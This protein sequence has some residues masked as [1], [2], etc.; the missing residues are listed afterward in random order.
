[1]IMQQ[2]LLPFGSDTANSVPIAAAA[3]LAK[4]H[5]ANITAMFYP[6]LPDPVIVD[7]MSG[8][9]VSYDGLDDEIEAQKASAGKK[10]LER[11]A[12]CIPP[13]INE[14]LNLDMES[15]SN[16]RQ[17][18]EVCRIHDVSLV[19]RSIENPHWQTLFEMALFEGGRPVV[20]VP[21][22]WNKPFGDTVGIAWNHSTETA[23]VLALS[24]PIIKRAK[25]VYIIEV[26]GWVHAGPDGAGL[27]RYLAGHGIDS[28]FKRGPSAGNAGERVLEVAE[29]A[30]VD[31]LIK[32]AFTQSRLTQMIFGGATRAILDQAKIP[33]IFAH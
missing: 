8:G 27:Q 3:D 13:V 22:N 9:V 26:D 10:I 25:K 29:K 12:I 18:G 7:P 2:I 17:V 24:M 20:V 15:L 11:A 31:F 6:R 19:G 14:K 5:G 1:M 30:N 21:Q 33:V 28:E 16:W 32:G 4:Q 23:R